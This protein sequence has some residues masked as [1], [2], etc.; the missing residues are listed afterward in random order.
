MGDVWDD[1]LSEFRP[2]CPY[3][4]DEDDIWECINDEFVD[5]RDGNLSRNGDYDDPVDQAEDER[6]FVVMNYRNH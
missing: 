2:S 4:D 1:L 5:W 6:G 3:D